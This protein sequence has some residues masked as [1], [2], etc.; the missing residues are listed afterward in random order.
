MYLSQRYKSIKI[1]STLSDLCKLLFGVPQGSVLGP[2]LF[3]LYTTSL[4]LVIG[5]QKGVKFHCYADDTQVYIHLSQ[6]NS[7]AAFEKLNKCLDDTKEW[8]SASKL[9]FNPDKTEFIVYGSKRQRDKVIAYLSSTILGCP[10]CPAELVK[11]LGL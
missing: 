2:L 8:M 6:K 7:S 1:G 4:S 3:S 10:L 11:N 9:K 5:K